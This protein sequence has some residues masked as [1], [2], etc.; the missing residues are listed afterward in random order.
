LIGVDKHGGIHRSEIDHEERAK[1][2]ECQMLDK[3]G[4]VTWT[5]KIAEQ[6]PLVGPAA[7]IREKITAGPLGA[8]RAREA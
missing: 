1:V 8:D 4:L 7:Q 6:D 5:I 3:L 2:I